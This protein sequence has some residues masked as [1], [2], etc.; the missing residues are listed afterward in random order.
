MLIENDCD[1][2]LCNGYYPPPNPTPAA[3]PSIID[4]DILNAGLREKL[5]LKDVFDIFYD[6]NSICECTCNGYY[7]PP[8]IE[9]N[10]INVGLCKND[11]FGMVWDENDIINAEIGNNGVICFLCKFF[12]VGSHLSL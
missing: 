10:G 11:I 7:Y 9:F 4:V 5:V 1:Y 6:E 3:G 12:V 8:T 2:S